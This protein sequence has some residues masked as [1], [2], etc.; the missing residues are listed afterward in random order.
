METGLVRSDLVVLNGIH[1]C[2]RAGAR[3]APYTCIEMH[4]QPA[5]GAPLHRSLDEDKTFIL[6]SGELTFRFADGEHTFSPGQQIVVKR[7]D[8]HGFANLQQH[9]AHM[10]LISSPAKHDDFF[11]AMAALSL[12]HDSADVHRVC[13]EFGQELLEA[14]EET[15]VS[16]ERQ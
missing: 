10:L 5:G 15:G 3:S 4:I 16:D 9:V 13:Q 12:P 6:L 11:R 7:G 8:A 2:L 14:P 1:A